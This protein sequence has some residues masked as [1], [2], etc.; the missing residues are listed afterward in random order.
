MTLKN[1]FLKVLF[2]L[3]ILK[4]FNLN[5]ALTLDA[6]EYLIPITKGIGYMHIAVAE[7][8]MKP[9]LERL[10]K[11]VNGQQKRDF[12]DVGVNVGQTLLMVNSLYPDV[13][14][15]GFEPNPV[16]VSYVQELK[17]LNK[18]SSATVFPVGLSD[19]VRMAELIFFKDDHADDTASVIENF[20]ERA[21]DKRTKI[22]LFKGDLL[23]EEENI[24]PG[25]LKIDVEGGELEVIMGLMETI[26]KFRPAVLCEI[27]PVYRPDN[28]FR[29]DRQKALLEFFNSNKYLLYRI[30]NDGAIEEIPTIEIHSNVALSNYVFVPKESPL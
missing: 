1:T 25:V 29:I 15:F 22:V 17:T 12:I 30:Y 23:I 21:K 19:K 7:P 18:I 27:L 8:W 11:Y 6:K 10:T 4:F 20:R 28:Y 13:N 2:R 5:G 24:H 14:Y 3:G 26:K 9:V 16:C